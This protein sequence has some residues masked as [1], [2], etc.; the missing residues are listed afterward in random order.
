MLTKYGRLLKKYGV[1]ASGYWPGESKTSLTSNSRGSS[2]SEKRRKSALSKISI[3]DNGDAVLTDAQY[4][5]F[6]EAF[7]LFDKNGGGTIDAA[8]LQKTLDDCG[9]YV[10]GDDLVE[11]MLSL[12]HDGNGEVDFDE[13]LTLMTNTD[14]FL[15][16][17]NKD[18]TDDNA[19]KREA[20]K[21]VVLFDALTEFL[22]KQALKGANEII[23]YYSKKYK[24]YHH[25]TGMKGPGIHGPLHQI[26]PYST[27]V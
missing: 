24:T 15:E 23:G 5:A 8:E 25:S 11:I 19:I 20:K 6:Q 17:L 14:V 3:D 7:E 16:V 2:S 27:G 4:Q 22:K 9:I 26:Y 13:F 18:A 12:D 1:M 10:N 21:R